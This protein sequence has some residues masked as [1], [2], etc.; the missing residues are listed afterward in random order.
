MSKYKIYLEGLIKLLGNPGLKIIEGKIPVL[1]WKPGSIKYDLSD[2][3]QIV[4]YQFN[5]L[6]LVEDEFKFCIVMEL[7]DSRFLTPEMES[8]IV[9]L[10][11]QNRILKESLKR[12]KTL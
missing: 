8:R 7:L 5:N 12:V 9:L 2:T 3:P 6:F 10:I 11:Q 4:Q 1:G